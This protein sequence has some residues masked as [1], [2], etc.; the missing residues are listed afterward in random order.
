MSPNRSQTTV[1]EAVNADLD[2]VS[3]ELSKFRCNSHLPLLIYWLLYCLFC[4]LFYALRQQDQCASALHNRAFRKRA[5]PPLSAAVPIRAWPFHL[6]A[7]I[8]S[9]LFQLRLIPYSVICTLHLSL[10]HTHFKPGCTLL[11]LLLDY[12]TPNLIFSINPLLM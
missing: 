7:E 3:F 12:L 2:N 9:F 5:S 8:S 11:P 10:L 4:Y 1:I 6:R